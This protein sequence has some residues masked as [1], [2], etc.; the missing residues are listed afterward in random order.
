MVHGLR[1]IGLH[2]LVEYGPCD[3]FFVFLFFSLF[4]PCIIRLYSYIFLFLY[5]TKASPHLTLYHLKGKKGVRR[6]ESP[7]RL[8]NYGALCL[9]TF[10]CGVKDFPPF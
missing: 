1:D 7:Y 10:N 8:K 3:A 5:I 2:G 4:L 9:V 6:L